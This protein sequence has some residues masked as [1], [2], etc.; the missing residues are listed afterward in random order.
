VVDGTVVV[1]EVDVGVSG[2]TLPMS[3]EGLSWVGASGDI[4]KG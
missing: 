1:D 2:N 3:L 4:V